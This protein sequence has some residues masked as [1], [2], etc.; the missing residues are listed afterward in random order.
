MD[1][2]CSAAI[3]RKSIIT[4]RYVVMN[5]MSHSPGS[6]HMYMYNELMRCIVSL[7]TRMRLHKL[8]RDFLW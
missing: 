6:L 2:V 1:D 8:Q 7:V 3:D 5:M 4:S